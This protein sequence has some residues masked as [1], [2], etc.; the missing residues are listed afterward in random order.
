MIKLNEKAK[1][2]IA[3]L[4]V[5]REDLFN[6]YAILTQAWHETGGFRHVIGNHNYWGIKKPGKWKGKVHQV[7]THEYIKGKKVIVRGAKF[8]DFPTCEE[9]LIWYMGLIKRLYKESYKYRSC[10]MLYFHWLVDG[11]YKYATDPRYPE[12][13]IRMCIALQKDEGIRKLING[14]KNV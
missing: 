2:F 8:I 6:D 7:T 10:P 11:K 13:L 4:V 5:S 12:K 3:C 1:L 9:G 14:D